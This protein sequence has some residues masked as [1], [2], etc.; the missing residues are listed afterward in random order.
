[1][2]NQFVEVAQVIHSQQVLGSAENADAIEPILL[3]L[4]RDCI[5]QQ[6]R[7]IVALHLHLARVVFR[8][9]HVFRHVRL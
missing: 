7:A 9:T 2:L 6:F 4:I 3:R 8:T 5:G 1:M